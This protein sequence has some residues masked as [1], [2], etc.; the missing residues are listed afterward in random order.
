VKLSLLND[1]E[2]IKSKQYSYIFLPD[3]KFN[4]SDKYVYTI[5]SDDVR[6]LKTHGAD[7]VIINRYSIEDVN[8]LNSEEVEF[9]I[10]NSQIS[11]ISSENPINRLSVEITQ[12]VYKT[13][14]NSRLLI[15]FT[16]DID[17]SITIENVSF[18]YDL[19]NVKYNQTSNQT[20]NK[21]NI[22]V[23]NNQYLSNYNFIYEKLVKNENNEYIVS[24]TQN[25]S[26]EMLNNNN[27][28]INYDYINEKLN[29][30][31]CTGLK[32]INSKIE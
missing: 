21:I 31:D 14:I 22:N 8:K 30:Y 11:I 6:V 27:I 2:E 20:S 1:N 5:S 23:S 19:I 24:D 9:G 29:I 3:L 10:I 12:S 15:E 25:I 26:P 13:T 7:E 18:F 32:I 16:N 4:N 28:T 17:N